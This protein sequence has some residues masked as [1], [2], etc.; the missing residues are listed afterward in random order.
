MVSTWTGLGEALGWNPSNIQTR[1]GHSI[2]AAGWDTQFLFT[3]TATQASF[4]VKEMTLH[5]PLN[6]ASRPCGR[7]TFLS[8]GRVM[9]VRGHC[10]HSLISQ[11]IVSNLP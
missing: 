3:V 7:S 10:S 6:A 5:V 11:I 4:E 2:V 8:D 9:F 1:G